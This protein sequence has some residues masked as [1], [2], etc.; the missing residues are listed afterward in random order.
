[1]AGS[2]RMVPFGV[3]A[4]PILVYFSRDWDVHWGYGVLTHGHIGKV[5]GLG[6]VSVGV[7][8]IPVETAAGVLEA[9]LAPYRQGS[10]CH[11]KVPVK[12]AMSRS[13][14]RAPDLHEAAHRSGNGS[15]PRGWGAFFAGGAGCR[16]G[17]RDLVQRSV[18]FLTAFLVGGVPLNRRQK[19]GVPLI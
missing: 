13:G 7:C 5:E 2:K 9:R 18:P 15:S 4:A 6:Y 11:I 12:G 10:S 17:H 19:K 8:S 3:G 14:V 16:I 1:M